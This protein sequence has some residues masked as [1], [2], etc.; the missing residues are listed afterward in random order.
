M[1]R[2]RALRRGHATP[3]ATLASAFLNAVTPHSIA[4]PVEAITQLVTQAT[5]PTANGCRLHLAA[6]G[7]I[8]VGEGL[9][10]PP[11]QYLL[12]FWG[13]R[14][15]RLSQG[16]P[17][18]FARLIVRG[19]GRASIAN[20]LGLA[21]P[22]GVLRAQSVNEPAAEVPPKPGWKCTETQIVTKKNLVDGLACHQLAVLNP[23]ARGNH[24]GKREIG[25]VKPTDVVE[26]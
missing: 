19:V 14:S 18:L 17:E 16:E 21:L 24:Q 13:E 3:H 10:E 20:R 11:P 4:A 23:P 7:D 15:H 9:I 8:L 5:D 25:G 12:L 6:S 22:P 2:P 1:A 26:T